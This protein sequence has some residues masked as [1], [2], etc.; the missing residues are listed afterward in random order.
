VAEE[1]A[2]ALK[3]RGHSVFFDRDQ[4][5]PGASYHTRIKREAERSDLIIFLISPES[6]ESGSYTLTELGYVRR[7]F[8]HPAGR[9][10]PVIVAPTPL[11]QI[12]SY[13]RAITLLEPQGNLAAEVA[14]A[15][16]S[17]WPAS[18]GQDTTA[19]NLRNHI[20]VSRYV[21]ENPICPIFATF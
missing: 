12:P 6:V 18:G 20:E 13:L 19:G 11:E 21:S 10:L 9:V 7:R 3:E 5:P 1:I 8:G 4:L 14:A 2:F 17:L 16:D 15:V